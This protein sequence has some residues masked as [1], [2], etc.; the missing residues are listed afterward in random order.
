[1]NL[2][3]NGLQRLSG[4]CN[5]FIA[6][7]ILGAC[8]LGCRKQETSNRPFEVFYVSDPINH[9]TLAD[10]LPKS[11]SLAD[12][13]ITSWE[14][15]LPGPHTNDD[16]PWHWQPTDSERS[17]ILSLFQDTQR[18]IV[19]ELGVVYGTLKIVDHEGKK[20]TINLIVRDKEKGEL[21]QVYADSLADKGASFAPIETNGHPLFSLFQKKSAEAQQ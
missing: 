6:A 19:K 7:C 2:I 5:C 17:S 14:F 11:G 18:V 10:V 15:Q 16:G 4:W 21:Y 13:S 20:F 8:I 3:R 12:L 1:M 9:G